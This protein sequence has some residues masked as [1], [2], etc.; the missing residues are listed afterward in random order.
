MWQWGPVLVVLDV[1]LK[2]ISIFICGNEGNS[3]VCLNFVYF[4]NLPA[5]SWK[6]YPF[7][8]VYSSVK[9]QDNKCIYQEMY[10][11]QG[12]FKRKMYPFKLYP[13]QANFETT[14]VSP[15]ESVFT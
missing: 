7:E 15:Y 5:Y 8:S 13:Y 11:P 2:F 10:P 4:P 9:F 3:Y 1:I 12:N 6:M 14:N